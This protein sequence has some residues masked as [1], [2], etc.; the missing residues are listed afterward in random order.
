MNYKINKSEI[1]KIVREVL[2]EEFANLQVEDININK[3]DGKRTVSVTKDNENPKYVDTNSYTQPYIFTD[4]VRGY[5]VYSIFKRQKTE[6]GVTDS[7]PLLNALKQRKGWQF[8]N[9]KNDLMLLLRNFVAAI[10]LLP[11]YDTII[12]TP[13]NNQLNQIVF[14]YLIRLI[15]HTTSYENFFEKFSAQDVYDNLIDDDYINSN[16][17]NPS[18][19]YNSIDE[20]FG[21]M[22]KL[23]NGI[24]SY[25]Y[26]QKTPYREA[27]IQ[28]MKVNIGVD[29]DLNYD[30]AINGKNVLIF[31]DTVTSGKTI[32]DSGKAICDMFAPKTLTYITLFSSLNDENIKKQE[33]KI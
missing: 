22:M 12:M 9:A 27:I 4:T 2:M 13:S 21:N 26:L 15:P 23:N 10:K 25:K 33:C 31:D 29:N 8:E 3:Q 18:S 19:V 6:D 20:A 30:E 11:K 16:F 5:T 14:K 32:S 24:F 7:N 1:R 28:S 17:E